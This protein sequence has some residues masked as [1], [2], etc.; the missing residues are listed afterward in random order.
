MAWRK[1]MARPGSKSGTGEASLVFYGVKGENATT[2]FAIISTENA[3]YCVK[4]AY[5][6]DK[7]ESAALPVR[8]GEDVSFAY[9]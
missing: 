7:V 2:A 4:K 3:R 5:Q 1:N 9:E 6:D 8:G